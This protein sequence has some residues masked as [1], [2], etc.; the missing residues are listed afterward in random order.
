MKAHPELTEALC[1][2]IERIEDALRE[3][4]YTGQPIQA[5]LAGGMAANYYCGNR[6]TRDIDADFSARL[7]LP[8]DLRVAYR[9]R[10][11]EDSFIYFDTHYNTSFALLHEDF[12][13]DA[14]IHEKWKEPRPDGKKRLIEL[15]VL[16]PVDLAVSKLARY[17]ENDRRDIYALALEKLITPETLRERAKE[18]M[19]DFQ[20]NPGPLQTTINIVCRDIDLHPNFEQISKELYEKERDHPLYNALREEQKSLETKPENP[21]SRLPTLISLEEAVR[22]NVPAAIETQRILEALLLSDQEPPKE[23]GPKPPGEN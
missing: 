9:K 11:G 4:G 7:I 21:I 16:S 2:L 18:A 17:S 22:Q 5:R 3:S 20:G 23:R 1:T 8:K 19:A 12:V 10:N 13:K 6:Y 14:V 15:R